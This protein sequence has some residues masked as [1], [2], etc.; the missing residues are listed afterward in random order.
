MV[1]ISVSSRPRASARAEGSAGRRVGR[2]PWRQLPSPRTAGPSTPRPPTR[3]RSGWKKCGRSGRD[4]T[5]LGLSRSPGS[6]TARD[7]EHPCP[8]VLIVRVSSRPRASARA[9]GSA[10]RRIGRI[11]WGQLHRPTPVREQQVPPLRVRP[12]AKDPG[13]KNADA[14]VGMTH[15][16]GCR[17]V[18]DLE[19]RETRSTRA[20]AYLSS[21]CHPDQGLQ[22]A[23]RDLLSA[24]LAGFRGVRFTGLR[25]SANS[26]S[27]H[28]A[29]AHPQKIRVEKMRTLRS[30]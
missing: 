2:I 24:V 17:E 26:R 6:R 11:S 15:Y 1:A 25:Q 30:G 27:L 9:E 5:L 13:G 8:G 4:D 10:V 16:W 18:P 22:P 20:P 21:V 19:P 7:A 29:S 28:S 3:K 14:A 12:P 23:W